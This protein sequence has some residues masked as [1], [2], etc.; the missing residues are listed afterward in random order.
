MTVRIS[1][2][3]A[4][5]SAIR[6]SASANANNAAI[7]FLFLR[8]AAAKSPR[9]FADAEPIFPDNLPPTQTAIGC[10]TMPLTSPMERWRHPAVLFQEVG[11][12]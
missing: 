11:A 12:A 1:H 5:Y 7:N 10:T 3:Q 2:L 9:H 8:N 6:V 4:Q